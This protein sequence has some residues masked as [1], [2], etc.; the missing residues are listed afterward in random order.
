MTSFDTTAH[1]DES[2]T[3]NDPSLSGIFN[4]MVSGIDENNRGALLP[5]KTVGHSCPSFLMMVSKKYLD[6]FFLTSM[7]K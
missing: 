7:T 4:S 5:P 6:F 1:I 2:F 3:H